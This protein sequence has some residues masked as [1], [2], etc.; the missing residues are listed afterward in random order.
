[1]SF[2]FFFFFHPISLTFQI[3]CLEPEGV[4]HSVFCGCWITSEHAVPSLLPERE[5]ERG[6]YCFH[7]RDQWVGKC[8]LI[9][10]ELLSQ[11]NKCKH[12]CWLGC[13]AERSGGQPFCVSVPKLWNHQYPRWNQ[14]IEVRFV[15]EGRPTSRLIKKRE[16]KWERE[17]ERSYALTHLQIKSWR[18]MDMYTKIPHVLAA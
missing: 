3:V 8:A 18:N 2:F 7:D 10:Q 9:L 16:S 6:Q 15:T 13:R 17:T 12:P 4:N 11:A 5:R 14:S 1:M